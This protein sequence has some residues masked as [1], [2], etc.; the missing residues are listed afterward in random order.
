MQA[1]QHLL[2]PLA[3]PLRNPRWSRVPY[4]LVSTPCRPMSSLPLAYRPTQGD[5]RKHTIERTFFQSAEC[6]KLAKAV[7]H[8]TVAND[9]HGMHVAVASKALTPGEVIESGV[10]R[11]AKAGLSHYAL[12]DGIDFH[13]GQG[14]PREDAPANFLASGLAMVYRRAQTGFNTELGV[15]PSA[16]PRAWEY[17]IKAVTNIARG[18]PLCRCTFA[19]SAGLAAIERRYG[20]LYHLTEDDVTRYLK[21]RRTLDLE[22][23]AQAGTEPEELHEDTLREHIRATRTGELPLVGFDGSGTGKTAVVLPHPEWAGFGAFAT[24]EIRKGEVVEWGLMRQVHVDGASNP[25]VFTWNPEGRRRERDNVWATGSNASMF[26]N[27][28]HPANVRFYRLFANFRY[29][30]IAKRDIGIGEELMHLYASSSWRKC[31]VS[32]ETLPKLL[33]IDHGSLSQ[34]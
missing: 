3:G 5:E 15:F 17:E 19:S 32:D 27:S 14:R 10:L 24:R 6:Q 13:T 1:M 4:V 31:F 20:D 2:R 21:Q 11:P 22:V 33:P 12:H 34:V 28:D 29:V 23:A 30:I 25:Y 7:C 16:Q 26:Y 9:E 8:A 18:A